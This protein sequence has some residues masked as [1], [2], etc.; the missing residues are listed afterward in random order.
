MHK[1]RNHALDGLRGVA[2]LLVLA[3]HAQIPGF[4]GG[5]LGVSIFFTISGYLIT[6]L[7]LEEMEAA[8]G[9][10]LARFWARRAR[11]LL[12]AA[13]FTIA[14]L[15]IA[16]KTSA[17]ENFGALLYHANWQQVWNQ[18]EYAALFATKPY[19][20]HFWSLAIEEQYYLLWPLM[21]W[22]LCRRFGT[23]RGAAIGIVG[24]VALA[25]L[26]YLAHGGDAVRTYYGTDL[27]GGEIA[28]GAAL[29]VLRRSDEKRANH[30]GR[31]G[32][33]ALVVL[34]AVMVT[35]NPASGWVARGGLLLYAVV[36][37]V[38]IAGTN[39]TEGWFVRVL[40]SRVLRTVGVISYGLYLYHWPIFLF[41]GVET[42][43]DR[44][45]ALA[46]TFALA[47]SSY[48]LLEKPIREQTRWRGGTLAALAGSTLLLAATYGWG[49]WRDTRGE[50]CFYDNRC[51]GTGTSHLATVDTEATKILVLGDSV[52]QVSTWGMRQQP[53]VR[54]GEVLLVGLGAGGCPMFGEK[55]RWVEN[56]EESWTET[57]DL[58]AML[59]TVRTWRPDVLL[60]MFTLSSQADVMVDGGWTNIGEQTGEAAWRANAAAVS[61]AA[62]AVGARTFWADAP[63][64][65]GVNPTFDEA[66]R[67]TGTYNK[68][69][70]SF[71]SSEPRA[72]KFPL[73]E[74]Y[75]DLPDEAFSDGVHLTKTWATKVGEKELRRLLSR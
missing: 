3:F 32:G 47:G 23:G 62:S 40:S 36:G 8:G 42:P 26:G 22:I 54:D 21:L 57:C 24:V 68:I 73:A 38:A 75:N 50:E 70:D 1:E 60:V 13:T 58:E 71:L 20:L 12:P 49:G 15:A 39:G 52:A 48:G 30:L 34:L 17:G 29:A 33:A 11:R 7:L 55:Y 67:R 2:V 16:G 10:S 72:T 41:V 46:S 65:R 27:R 51:R 5:F 31:G 14:V 59:E 63:A 53:E 19:L 18:N 69:I 74:S 61:E 25:F 66:G 64:P 6:G 44:F 56:G 37:V 4:S 28:I 35:S 45:V 9:V 43:Q